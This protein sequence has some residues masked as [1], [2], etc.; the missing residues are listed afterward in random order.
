M[1]IESM[2]VVTIEKWLFGDM[3][4]ARQDSGRVVLIPGGFPGEQWQ[5]VNPQMRKGVLVDRLA[6]C[7]RCPA[8]RLHRVF[9]RT[10]VAVVPCRKYP[11]HWKAI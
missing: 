3:G 4:L 8:E 7:L 1:A 2:P 9:T 11:V 10:C 6:K 5:L